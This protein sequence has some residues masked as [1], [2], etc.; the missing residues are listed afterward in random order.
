[1]A[2]SAVRPAAPP[3]AQAK[4]EAPPAAQ[5][6]AELP[7]AIRPKAARRPP[8]KAEAPPPPPPPARWSTVALAAH[9]KATVAICRITAQIEVLQAAQ[10]ERNAQLACQGVPAKPKPPSR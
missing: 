5:A 9:A 4:A 1:M 10:A 3:A 2:R 6:K 8:A 7:P